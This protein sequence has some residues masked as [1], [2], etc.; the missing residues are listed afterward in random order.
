MLRKAFFAQPVSDAPA[1]AAELPK[2]DG[3]GQADQG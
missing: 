1:G 2:E 3:N